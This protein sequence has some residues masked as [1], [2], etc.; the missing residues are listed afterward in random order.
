[1]TFGTPS[2]R[3]NPEATL[4]FFI[5]KAKEDDKQ[6]GHIHGSYGFRKAWDARFS[7]AAL[8]LIREGSFKAGSIESLLTFLGPIAPPEAATCAKELLAP[9]AV[10]DSA[11]QDRTVGVLTS[12]LGA[13]PAA[14][15]DFAW[16]IVESDLALAERV[17]LG[18]SD[19]FDH[20]RMKFL[21]TLTES[22]LAIL[23]LKL[24]NLFPPETDPPRNSGFSGVSSR[25][26][27]GWFRNDV[28]STLEARGTEEACRELL[29]LAN[30]LP[31]HSVWLRWRHYNTRVSKRRISWS[32]PSPKTVLLLAKRA[33]GRLVR[34][35]DDLLEV[36]MES[37]ERFQVQL[38]NSTL[39]RS[40]VLWRYAGADTRQQDFEPHDEA[41]LANEIARWLRDDLNQRR[42]VIGREV[43]PR[44]GQRT[45]IWVDATACGDSAA[46]VQTMT[47]V[48]EIK[49]CWNA[50]ARSA[51]DSQ[52]VGDY[53]RPNGLTHGVYIVGWFVCHKWKASRNKLSSA[54]LDLARQE[55][56]QLVSAYD[57]KANPERVNGIVLDCRYPV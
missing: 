57:G 14:T 4:R 35:V 27:V 41:F 18:I 15:W 13:M 48:I 47:V 3:L 11:L 33:E 5:R 54:T 40:E 29:R 25:Q 16:P 22:K 28:I 32:P 9:A 38:T 26:S 24:H 51:V 44:R 36:V 56:S 7:A 2:Y 23:Y 50:E 46:S 19:R 30:A 49:G 10:A 52:L 34:D 1:M 6:H 12:C 55:I 42:V 8:D 43:Q 21:P 45:D 20:D 17:L 53:L 31:T 39:P 37:L